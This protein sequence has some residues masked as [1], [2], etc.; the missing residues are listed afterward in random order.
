M[1]LSGSQRATIKSV[2]HI[3]LKMQNVTSKILQVI[4]QLYFRIR[5]NKQSLMQ[6]EKQEGKNNCIKFYFYVYNI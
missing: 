6:K 1:D 2:A 5:I 3:L 4:F